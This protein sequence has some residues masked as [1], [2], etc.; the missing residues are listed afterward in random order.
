MTSSGD[1][2]SR[3]ALVRHR[4]EQNTADCRRSTPAVHPRPQTG[5][6][7]WSPRCIAATRRRACSSTLHRLDLHLSEQ[8]TAVGDFVADSGTPHSR[9]Y[10][11]ADPPDVTSPIVE[12]YRP[13]DQRSQT[14]TQYA[15]PPGDGPGKDGPAATLGLAA[16]LGEQL[17]TA[18]PSAVLG[19]LQDQLDSGELLALAPLPQVQQDTFNDVVAS[20]KDCPD[21]QAPAI[22]RHFVPLLTSTVRFLA[23]RTNRGRDKHTKKTAYLFAPA[24][25]ET[26]PHE[27]ELQ[28]D[29]HD[30]LDAAGFDVQMEAIDRSGGRADIVVRLPGFDIVIECKREK[31]K[32]SREDLKSYLGQTIAYQA[33]GVTL[34]MLAVLD[35]TPKPHWLANIRDNMWTEHIQAPA[36]EQRDRWAV[37]VRVPGN[38]QSPSGM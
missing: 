22:R 17:L 36:P 21:Y 30:F 35:L 11:R 34:G 16:A 6:T 24:P 25:G 28:E 19:R 5:Q 20:L 10:R 2:F 18:L 32:A 31:R 15:G 1:A 12:P 3:Q 8:N 4:G 23:N 38:R 29:L 14:L 26:L 13:P 37:V 7:A 9:Q 33:T 27:V